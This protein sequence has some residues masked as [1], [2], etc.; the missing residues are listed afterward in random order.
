VQF[1]TDLVGP[2]LTRSLDAVR[3]VPLQLLASLVVLTGVGIA[4]DALSEDSFALVTIVNTIVSIVAQIIITRSVALSAGWID[5]GSGGYP[6]MSLFGQSIVIGLG[7]LVGLVLLIL[8]GLYAASRWF[9]AAQIVILERRPA[10][11]AMRESW[12]RTE[13]QWLSA[14]VI[15]LVVA[16][17]MLV[18]VVSAFFAYEMEYSAFSLPSIVANTALSAAL[19]FAYVSATVFWLMLRSDHEKYSAD[20]FS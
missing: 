5:A 2:L 20:I 11:D 6:I 15:Y 7:V 4:Y 19:L 3:M 10:M 12:A 14:F 9:I 1:N 16:A 17:G 8:P 13:T 18:P